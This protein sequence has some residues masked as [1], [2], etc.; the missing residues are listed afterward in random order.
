MKRFLFNTLGVALVLQGLYEWLINGNEALSSLPFALATVC[1]V[2][3][4]AVQEENRGLGIFSSLETHEKVF[5]TVVVVIILAIVGFFLWGIIDNF[6]PQINWK[7]FLPFVGVA[8]TAIIVGRL[9]YF[10]RELWNYVMGTEFFG[11]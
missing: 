1:L 4:T 6:F 2:L 10:C 3:A 8:I 5:L 7:Y 11:H 9:F